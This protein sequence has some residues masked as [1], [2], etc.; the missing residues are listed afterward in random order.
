MEKLFSTILFLY[1]FSSDRLGVQSELIPE[2]GKN[3]LHK[4]FV[5]PNLLAVVTTTSLPLILFGVIILELYFE[6]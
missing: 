1:N 2:D 3:S 4:L 5:L 6:R